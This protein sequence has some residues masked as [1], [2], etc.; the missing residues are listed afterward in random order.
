MNFILFIFFFLLTSIFTLAGTKI[1]FVYRITK[2]DEIHPVL[3]NFFS[4]LING[5][6]QS[7]ILALTVALMIFSISLSI[8]TISQAPECDD[9]IQQSIKTLIIILLVSE[10]LISIYFL[11]VV[12]LLLLSV[13]FFLFLFYLFIN[14]GPTTG[15][16]VH[17]RGHYRK[18]TYVR[19]H[20]RR[21]PRR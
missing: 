8:I 14:S 17:V 16:S 1:L 21:K 19:S 6:H 13:A 20:T 15:R 12:F 9:I 3:S 11:L 4:T 2:I 7:L 18:G 5:S 10:I